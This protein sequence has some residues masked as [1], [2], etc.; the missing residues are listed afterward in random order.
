[1]GQQNRG[2]LLEQC[3][4]VL[5]LLQALQKSVQRF[6]VCA[7]TKKGGYKWLRRE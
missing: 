1:M 2:K 6:Q 5:Y 3:G 7:V 4:F